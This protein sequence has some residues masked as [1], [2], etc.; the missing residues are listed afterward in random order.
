MNRGGGGIRAGQG[1]LLPVAD[2]AV[3]RDNLRDALGKAAREQLHVQLAQG[4][5]LVVVQSGGARHLAAEPDVRIPPVHCRLG[6]AEDGPVGVDKEPLDR[7]RRALM[8]PVSNWLE[9]GALPSALS[10]AALPSDLSSADR[11]SY[12]EY[13]WT[14]AE[15]PSGTRSTCRPR[16][17]WK[18][19]RSTG[20]LSYSSRQKAR[21]AKITSW[22]SVRSVWVLRTFTF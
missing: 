3:S 13:C 8:K 4:Y 14:W 12:M 10:S 21:T 2:H 7:R 19:G 22:A 18:P 20:R 11:R 5:G 17:A 6:A 1:P 16:T 9:P 15:A